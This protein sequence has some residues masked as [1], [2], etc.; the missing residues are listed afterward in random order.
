[1]HFGVF[2]LTWEPVDQP[3]IDLD[4]ALQA[5]Q[6]DAGRFWA[7]EPGQARVVTPR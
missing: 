4:A 3:V 7:L 6:I 5:N 1:M 2:Q